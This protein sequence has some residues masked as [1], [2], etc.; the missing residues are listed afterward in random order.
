MDGK[1]KFHFIACEI[2]F[3]EACYCASKSRSVVDITFVPKKLHDLGEAKMSEALQ[4]QIELVD[5]S[6][7]DAILM[8]YGLCS[9][10]V[11]GLHADIPLVI[12][13]AHDC[14]TLL[15]GSKE[16]YSEY[17]DNNPGTYF[18]SSGWIERDSETGEEG[19]ASQLG[20]NKTYEEYA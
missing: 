1:K 7:Y 3:R 20:I 12:P 5:A 6:K 8:G 13:R 18:H 16:L 11:R 15:M 4:R 14:I 9:Y 2:L 17:F 19:I 10:G